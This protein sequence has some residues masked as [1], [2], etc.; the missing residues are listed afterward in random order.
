M[1]K[2]SRLS[3]AF[4]CA[5]VVTGAAHAKTAPVT[6]HLKTAAGADAGTATLSQKKK[7]VAIKVDL[8]GLPPGEHAIHIHQ[9]PK[10]DPPD[11]KS[12]G[13]HF[14]PDNKKHGSKNPEGAHNG[15]LPLNL[16]VGADGSVKKTFLAEH[17]S[18]D[19]SAANSVVANGGTSLMVHE[20]ADDMSTDPTGNAGGRIACGIIG[21][22][23][24]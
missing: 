4:L 15:D 13:S 7:G 8:K 16:T 23:A 20:K 18:L 1:T 14:N 17:I 6:V 12:A 24:E 2:L 3:L 21:A 9:T 22:S 11:F 19:P 10:C 5:T